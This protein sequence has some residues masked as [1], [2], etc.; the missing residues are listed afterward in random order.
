VSPAP[1]RRALGALFAKEWR[2][3]AASRATLLFAAALG[4]LVGHAFGVAVRAYAEAS[5]SA[6]GP[7][8]LAQGL[9]PL[10]GLVVP[11]FGAYAL[12]AA[13]LFPF[14]VIRLVS[15]EKESGALRLLLQ[16]P[17][18]AGTQLAVKAAT[19]LAAWLL[20][21]T[22]GL[23]A[24]AL[25]GASGGHLGA[26]ETLGVLLGHLLRG[27]LVVALGALAAA[28]T[29][30]AASAAVVALAVT[31]GAW[32]LDFAAQVNGGALQTVAQYTPDAALRTFERGEVRLDVTAVVVL[33]AAGLLALAAAWQHPGRTRA[34]RLGRTAAVLALLAVALPTAARLRPSV[35]ASEDR[36][37][38][39]APADA[40]A[41][42]ALRAPLRVTVHLAPE[43]PRL[44]DLERG[45]LRK[46]R[47]TLP[48]VEVR[49]APTTST[50]LFERPG[51]HYGEVW[52][53]LR[54][55]RALQRS[56]TE[57]IVLETVYT[58][59]GLTPPTPDEAPAYPGYPLRASA[60]GAGWL[61]YGGWPLGV[62]LLWLRARRQRTPRP[63]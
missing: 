44:A 18:G 21:W 61:L 27:A 46:L 23:L 36:R 29:E 30:S 6:G 16:A 53:E 5:G 28:V 51:E 25:W 15:A 12:A 45:V 13:L 43:D 4:P 42:G 37:N 59:A 2:E 20:A 17:V 19:L 32:A 41:L 50:G 40:R 60:R 38:S 3:L 34:A 8:A 22:P 7:A 57:P 35:D 55:R 11:T 33:T 39:L 58:L 54:G 63:N 24:L 14:V 48:E 49:Y 10:D 52:Y 62:A 56:T 47:R 1:R 9:S 26:A 31:L